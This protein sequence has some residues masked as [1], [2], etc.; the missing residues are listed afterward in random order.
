MAGK[1][2][3]VVGGSAAGI[4]AAISAK[5]RNKDAHVT[6][7]RK[8]EKV[9]VP[10]G[11]PYIYGTLGSIDKNV[12]PDALLKD[13]ELIVDQVTDIDR[14]SQTVKTSSGKSVSYDKLILTTGSIPIVPPIPGNDLEN[15]LSIKKEMDHLQKLEKALAQAKNVVVIGGGFIGVEFADECRK[16]DLDVTIVEML[17][18]CLQ[19]ACDEEFSI[20]AEDTL[21]ERG[22][23]ILTE[24]SA[25]SIT[26][27]GKAEYVNLSNGDKL[28][29]DVVILGIGVIPNTELAQKAGLE[30]GEKRGIKVDEYMRTSDPNILAAGDCAEKFCFFTGNAIPLRLASIAGREARIAGANLFEPCIKNTGTIGTFS[31]A[32]GSTAIGVTGL[33]ERAAKDMS[34]DVVIGEAAA[35]DKHPGGMPNAQEVKVKLLFERKTGNIVGGCACGGT[36]SGEMA[37]VLAVAV[38]NK[39]TADQVATF[40]VGTHPALTASPIAYQIV[41]AA[42]QAAV[43]IK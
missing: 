6:V 9:Q 30:I 19:L 3:V 11:I 12:I 31:T 43:Q 18:H 32:F 33:T 14:G 4:T 24:V 2:V 37:N 10:C 1:N 20:K 15:V 17:P 13:M 8:E 29:A 40:P 39:M 35:V 23:K 36:V 42:E 16:R 26:G 34:L 22:V 27:N 21:K 25:Q 7:I 41:N 5:R 28:K 38:V